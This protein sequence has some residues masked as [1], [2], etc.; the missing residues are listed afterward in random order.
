MIQP[1]ATMVRSTAGRADCFSI[2]LRS[3]PPA[4]IHIGIAGVAIGVMKELRQA[5]CVRMMIPT[6]FAPIDLHARIAMGIKSA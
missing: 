2:A 5:V 1:T 4:A 6:G 3:Y